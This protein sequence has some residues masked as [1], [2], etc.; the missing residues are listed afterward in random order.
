M[1]KSTRIKVAVFA[2][3]A[4]LA[5]AT[6]VTGSANAAVEGGSSCYTLPG[7][8]KVVDDNTHETFLG[9]YYGSATATAG[10]VN[11][12]SPNNTTTASHGEWRQTGCGTYSDTD[13]AFLIG[14]DGKAASTI[15]FK[16]N[17]SVTGKNTANFDFAFTINNLDG[18]FVTSGASTG[19][20]TRIAVQPR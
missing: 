6:A 9:S 17:I 2:G 15:T 20:A 11:F 19:K 7:S 1:R 8:W 4:A 14:A 12:T 18:S 13:V 16:A 3:V 5:T 10:V